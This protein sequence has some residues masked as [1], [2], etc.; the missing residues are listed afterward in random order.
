[1][2]TVLQYTAKEHASSPL[3]TVSRIEDFQY[4]E[5]LAVPRQRGELSTGTQCTATVAISSHHVNLSPDPMPPASPDHLRT[6]SERDRLLTSANFDD[7]AASADKV[8]AEAS[9]QYC[10][11]R[12]RLTFE[13]IGGHLRS[14]D[15]RG[16][17][18]ATKDDVMSNNRSACIPIPP[19]LKAFVI[20]IPDSALART[21]LLVPDG[22]IRWNAEIHSVTITPQDHHAAAE[23]RHHVFTVHPHTR[24]LCAPTK[25]A[26]LFLAAVYA[27]GGCGAVIPG[28]GK[29]GGQTA[30]ELLR[31]C[32]GCTPL[33]TSEERN[34]AAVS[35]HAS[36]TPALQLLCAS[37]YSSSRGL[38]FLWGSAAPSSQ[39]PVLWRM[40]E[41]SYYLQQRNNASRGG[42][43]QLTIGNLRETLS[44]FETRMVLGQ[45]QEF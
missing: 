15:F 20:L 24:H 45:V 30:L 42:R 35:A 9:L 44:S 11:L 16:Y 36:H 10:I 3:M 26:R 43:V 31:Q 28:L 27:A 1:M 23:A 12:H 39:H 6:N 29:T 18:I 34:L 21:M 41:E 5:V 25:E 8:L 40:G 7:G 4:I 33:S 14:L 17:R 37:I 19:F 22:H 38:D 13:T 32:A 2:P